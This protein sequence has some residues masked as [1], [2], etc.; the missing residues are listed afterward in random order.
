MEQQAISSDLIRGHIDTIILHTLLDGD[1]FAQQISDCVEQKSDE[2]Y[3][4]NQAT[5]YSSLKRLESLKYVTSYWYDTV[6]GR[7]KYFKLTEAGKETVEKNL[8]SWSYSRAIIDK[9]MDCAPQ[10]IIKTQYIEKIVKIE[11]PVIVSQPIPASSTQKTIQSQTL[12]EKTETIAQTNNL[13]DNDSVVNTQETIKTQSTENLENV[14]D[15]KQEINFRNILNGLIKATTVQKQQPL[16][17][18]EPLNK[19]DLQEEIPEKLKL[20]ETL[21]TTDYNAQKSN[22]NGKIDFGDLTLKAAKEGYKIRIS[23]KDSA[24]KEGSLLINKAN[25]YT[26]V[27]L[28]FIMGLEFLYFAL[29]HNALLN[30]NFPKI[31]IISALILVYPVVMIIKYL[32]SPHKKVT[33][34]ISADVILTTSIVVFNLL[35]ITFAANLLCNVNFLDTSITL[36]SLIIPA[37]LYF[38]ILFYSTLRFLFAKSELC[39][40]K[41]K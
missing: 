35:L 38:D 6:G 11:K 39:I 10:P 4:I 20:N 29:R 16:T 40:T 17:E 31:A 41:R 22:N 7:R 5:L 26:A 34:N 13:V 18:L 28:L 15:T 33:K 30:L 1:K 2:K 12:E 23:S 24:V 21:D 36:F 14:S 3:K 8:S 27:V 32:K 25:V 9:L 19:Q 37:V